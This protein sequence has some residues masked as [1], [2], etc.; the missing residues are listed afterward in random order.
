MKNK[1][2]KKS[3]IAIFILLLC[4]LILS[5]NQLGIFTQA[6]TNC[7]GPPLWGPVPSKNAWLPGT[8]VSVIIFDTPNPIDRQIISDGIRKWNAQ[9]A[10]NCSNVTFLPAVAAT[11]PYPGTDAPEGTIWVIRT[12]DRS[13]MRNHYRNE[14]TPQQSVKSATMVISD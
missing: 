6:Q 13:K 4:L 7:A 2:D 10:A 3:F 5:T 8:T 9:S 1:T 14:N 12:P 11:S